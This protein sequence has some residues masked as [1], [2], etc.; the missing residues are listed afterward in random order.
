M[1]PEAQQRL[2]E[3]RELHEVETYLE[4]ARTHLGREPGDPELVAF[5]RLA[6]EVVT[7]ERKRLGIAP[8]PNVGN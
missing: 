7:Q 3:L 5:V 1:R 2:K 4:R 6:E 8:S